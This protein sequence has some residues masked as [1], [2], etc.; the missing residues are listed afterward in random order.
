M[1]DI[2]F[3]QEVQDFNE[4]IGPVVAALVAG[5]HKLVPRGEVMQDSVRR[6]LET[7]YNCEV[8]ELAIRPIKNT[9]G[10]KV[11]GI[12]WRNGH[13]FSVGGIVNA[14]NYSGV[15]IWDDTDDPFENL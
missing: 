12:A 14:H 3:N 7:E 1:T 5:T 2:P 9:D 10:W 8:S 13:R 15:R 11:D 4:A 6:Y